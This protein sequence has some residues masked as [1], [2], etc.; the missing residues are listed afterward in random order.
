VAQL[1]YLGM[2]A[3]NQN[4]IQEE[5]K[6]RQ[7]YGDACY[8][9]VQNIPLCFLYVRLDVFMAVTM[10]NAILWDVELCGHPEYGSNTFV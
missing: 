7:N 9:S 2:T 8:Q 10:K 4:L 3:T 5:I 6:R 1:K